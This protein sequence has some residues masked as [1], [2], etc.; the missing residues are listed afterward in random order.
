MRGDGQDLDRLGKR[1]V[2]IRAANANRQSWQAQTLPC[3]S[4]NLP[5][6]TGTASCGRVREGLAGSLSRACFISGSF[7]GRTLGSEPGTIKNVKRCYACDLDKSIDD[8]PINRTRRDGHGS[9]C[10]LCK[11]DYNAAHYLATR[12]RFNPGRALSRDRR[13]EEAREKVSAYLREHPCADCGETDIV[14][15]EFDHQDGKTA[16]ISQLIASG[17]SWEIISREIAKC[18]VVCA[19]DHHRRTAKT[20]GWYK[21]A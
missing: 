14:V 11:S 12:D 18:E 9:M 21:A 5:P 6:P 17:S 7:N 15:L 10:K 19:N 16:N 1:R 4:S 13:R 20:F 2:R 3:G 8:F